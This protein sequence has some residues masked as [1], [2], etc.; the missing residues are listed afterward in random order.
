MTNGSVWF[1]MLYSPDCGHC[2]RL[3]PTLEQL[4]RDYVRRNQRVLQCRAPQF[5]SFTRMADMLANTLQSGHSGIAI[6][7]ADCTEEAALAI[8]FRVNSFPKLLLIEGGRLPSFRTYTG[9][10]T[11]QDLK[12]YVEG[13]YLDTAGLQWSDLSNPMGPWVAWVF[14]LNPVRVLLGLLPF[15]VG[16][17]GNGLL[18]VSLMAAYVALPC[19]TFGAMTF[20]LCGINPFARSD[21]DTKEPRGDLILDD[22]ELDREE[23]RLRA[24][25]EAAAW[26]A[27]LSQAELNELRKRAA[28]QG[29]H[30]ESLEAAI[31][32]LANGEI[33]PPKI[34]QTQLQAKKGKKKI[35]V[36]GRAGDKKRA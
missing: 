12:D 13:D 5:A 16:L 3:T 33:H 20:L 27:K 10:R 2:E 24:A 22:A 11:E 36:R 15:E 34:Q 17:I 30:E 25:T 19:V 29:L 32:A 7:K 35:S 28:E 1:V 4:A 21:D 18:L 31:T 14:L 8:R 26:R 23:Q 9:G 6:G